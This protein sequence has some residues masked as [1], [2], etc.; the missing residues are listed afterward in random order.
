[1]S[2][3]ER[4]CPACGAPAAS[5]QRFCSACGTPLPAPPVVETPAPEPEPETE[6]MEAA[7]P[8]PESEPEPTEPEPTEP[9]PEPIVIV[10]TPQQPAAAAPPPPPPPSPP[11]GD[12]S[13]DA[14]PSPRQPAAA[15]LDAAPAS[16][17]FLAS[18]FDMSFTA[19]VT[20]KIIKIL[21]VLSMIAIGLGYLGFVLASFSSSVGLGLLVLVIVGPLVSLFYLAWVRVLLEIAIVFFRIHESTA[22]MDQM[23]RR[24]A[25]RAVE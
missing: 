5:D 13:G 1:M 17:G 14:T 24:R 19:F 6:I 22:D 8:E 15:L 16:I 4:T 25:E 23:M 3:Q 10:G 20:P 18:L 7:A 11:A 9:E 2:A 12:E 21:Y